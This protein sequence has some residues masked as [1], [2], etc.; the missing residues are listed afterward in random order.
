MGYGVPA[1]RRREGASRPER[2]VICFVRRR[3]LPDDRAGAR[4]RGAVR[5][6]DRRPRRQ[7]RHVRDDP[8]AP[9]AAVPR[10]GRRHR[11]RQPGLRG[12][13][14]ARSARTARRSSA[15]TS[16][17]RRSSARSAPAGRRCSQLR[18]DPEAIT[19]RTTLSAIRAGAMSERREI[20]V[21]GLPEPISHYTDAVLGRRPA[22]RLGLRPGRRRRATSS[23]ATSSRR[24]GRCFANIALVL[25]RGGRQVRRRRQGDRVPDRHRR[26]RRGEHG[27]AGGLRRV[28]AREHA[29][30]GEPAR[31]PGRAHRGRS[32]RLVP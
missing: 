23:P 18:I 2:T 3:R 24:R 9:G 32:G 22:L 13:T 15:P 28:A 1:A 29:R 26:P 31:D 6:A 12:A 21:R 17:R 25:A 20:R 7:Q 11:S 5:P 10:A 16:S 8:H 27:P 14:R 30:R 4:D 19:P